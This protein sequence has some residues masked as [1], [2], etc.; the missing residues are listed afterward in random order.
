MTAPTPSPTASSPES[1][2]KPQ[3]PDL[4]PG[5]RP[6]IL[7]GSRP[8]GVQHLGNYI[9][10]LRQWV[11]LQDEFECFFMVADWH[12]LTGMYRDTSELVPNIEQQVV[13]WLSVGLDP[14]RATIFIQSAVKEH[15]ELQLLLGMFTPLGLMERCTSWKEQVLDQGNELLRT[16][17]FLGYP[18]LQSADILMYQ[19]HVVPVGRDQVEHIEKC[20]DIAEKVNF[21]Y[22]PVFVI[23]QWK[24]SEIPVLLGNDGRKMSKSY[25]NCIYLRDDAAEVNAKTDVMVTDPARVRRHDPGNPEVCSVYSYHKVFTEAEQVKTIDVECRRAGIGCR[26]CKKMLAKSLNALM[27]AWREKRAELTAHPEL[28]KDVIEAGNKVAQGRARQTME[29][30][31]DMLHLYR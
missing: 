2:P 1:A 31:R 15:A 16:Y 18:C 8:T 4:K 11:P 9:G 12:A 26:D 30:V 20:Q 21:L 28:A 23:P 13:D 7:S 5:E 22:G 6:R 24:I 3:F 10:A 17:G 19:A 29:R 27:D 14:A 25:G